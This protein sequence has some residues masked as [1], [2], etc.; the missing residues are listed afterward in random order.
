VKIFEKPVKKSVRK[1]CSHLSKNFLLLTV[2]RNPN[3]LDSRIVERAG[4]LIQVDVKERQRLFPRELS[5]KGRELQIKG[6]SPVDSS[7][8]K[9]IIGDM[10]AQEIKTRAH[11]VWNS[12]LRAHKALG[13]QLTETLASDFKEANTYFL[14]EIIKELSE[15]IMKQPCFAKDDRANS[16]LYSAQK[17]ASEEINIEVDLYV[18][19]LAQESKNLETVNSKVKTIFI[20]HAAE[21]KVVAE[22]VK[23]QIENV[24]CESVSVFVSSITI[25]PGQNWFETIIANIMEADAF[26]VIVTP[27]SERR[28]FVWF[29]IGFSW[30]RKLSEKSEIYALCVPPIDPGSLL[31]PLCRLQAISL[32]EEEKIRVFFERLSK[33]FN[34]GNLKAL[35]VSAIVNSMPEYPED[36]TD[37]REIQNTV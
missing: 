24:F 28:P 3:M 9:K 16:N 6:N 18:D 4:R 35:D 1:R 7:S 11:I 27:L 26:I 2:E 37:E 15:L 30:V 34:M 14:D 36:M 8:G 31:E 19:S 20:S 5:R 29:E 13:S 22:E 10:F 25:E 23:V 21:D 32:S 33:H 17:D 12:L